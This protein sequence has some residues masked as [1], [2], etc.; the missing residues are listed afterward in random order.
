MVLID[1]FTFYN[2]LDMLKKRLAYLDP[3]VD[4]FV[5]VE[6]T[7]THR[8]LPK[9]LL[10]QKHR[11]AFKAWAHKIVHVVVDDNP[12]GEDPW[13]RENHQRNCI[14]RGLETFDDDALVMVSDV[15]EFPDRTMIPTVMPDGR[16]AAF[17]MV[18]FVYR[19]EYVNDREPW[20]GTVLAHKRDVVRETPQ[21]LRDARWR[22]PRLMYAGWHFSSFGDAAFVT[23]KAYNFSHCLEDRFTDKDFGSYIEKGIHIGGE[24]TLSKT[25]EDILAK[26]PDQLKTISNGLAP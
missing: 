24:Y 5:L 14:T 25:S 15:D 21:A 8:G 13:T 26:V 10:F 12:T 23:N 11:D 9:D 6:S 16:V 3:V 19:L 18:S 1:C 4:A 2:E 22:L 7:V 20:M 17:N